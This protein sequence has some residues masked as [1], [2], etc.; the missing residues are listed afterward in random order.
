METE[1]RH[2]DMFNS[3]NLFDAKVRSILRQYIQ[4][5]KE[6]SI[7]DSEIAIRIKLLWGQCIGFFKL[8]KLYNQ[9]K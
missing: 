5:L 6:T 8:L 3:F 9:K 7:S 1:L 4:K 2:K